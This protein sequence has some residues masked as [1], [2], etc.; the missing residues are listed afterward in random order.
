MALERNH[1][2]VIVAVAGIMALML[3]G[4]GV[5]SES[6]KPGYVR[7]NVSGKSAVCL[8]FKGAELLDAGPFVSPLKG[9]AKVVM[10]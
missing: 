4:A 5:L 2:L 8:E 7:I 3:V 9:E 1:A 6:L 10:P